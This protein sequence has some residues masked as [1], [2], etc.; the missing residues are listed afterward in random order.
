M[1]RDKKS[2]YQDIDKNDVNTT[3]RNV[4]GCRRSFEDFVSM[5][6]QGLVDDNGGTVVRNEG[7]S[8]ET[9]SLVFQGMSVTCLGESCSVCDKEGCQSFDN[10]SEAFASFLTQ[11]PRNGGSTFVADR[12]RAMHAMNAQLVRDDE[13][14]L[15]SGSEVHLLTPEAARRYFS[16]LRAANLKIV[17]V[18]GAKKAN[19]AGDMV[20]TVVDQN[21]VRFGLRLGVAYAMD[22]VPMNLLSVSSLCQAGTI[23]H[24]EKGNSWLQH[25]GMASRVPNF[26]ERL[27]RP[28]DIFTGVVNSAV[29]QL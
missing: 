24:F 16:N 23:L 18:T 5:S 13:M 6:T 8:P 27:I 19:F 14:I 26:E 25:P 11:L 20:L 29:R 17:G 9:T 15:D 12:D 28:L 22:S 7:D 2:R 3:E 4:N 1:A 21:N 10:A